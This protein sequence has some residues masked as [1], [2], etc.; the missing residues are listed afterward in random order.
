MRMADTLDTL[1]CAHNLCLWY[2]D[3]VQTAANWDLA[4]QQAQALHAAG[5]GRIGTDEATFTATFTQSSRAQIEAIKQA[6]EQQFG[7]SLQV[8]VRICFIIQETC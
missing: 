5:V 6:Y 3:T 7:Q 2:F 4:A 1:V 8:S